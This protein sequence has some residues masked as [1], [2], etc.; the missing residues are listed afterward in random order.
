MTPDDPDAVVEAVADV[1]APADPVVMLDERPVPVPDQ[2][3]PAVVAAPDPVPAAAV[4]PVLLTDREPLADIQARLRRETDE[5]A[6]GGKM[7]RQA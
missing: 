3:A 7:R 1:P 6:R 4:A 5:R 2:V